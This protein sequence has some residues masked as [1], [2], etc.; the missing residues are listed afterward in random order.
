MLTSMI[1]RHIDV[2]HNNFF[3]LRQNV[4]LH[5]VNKLLLVNNYSPP[6]P[7][8][9]LLR[10]F[11]AHV[12]P[13]DNAPARKSVVAMAAVRDCRFE[14][15]DATPAWHTKLFGGFPKARGGEVDLT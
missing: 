15:F 12:F 11:G 5:Y 13:Q 3:V 2:F 9:C 8:L 1:Y 6:P 7:M 10:T 4:I 14:L